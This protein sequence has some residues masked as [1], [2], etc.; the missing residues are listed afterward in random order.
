MG[1]PH[2]FA[3]M[4]IGLEVA[5]DDTTRIVEWTDSADME[6]IT[7]EISRA[8][9]FADAVLINAHVHEPTNH[10]T[11]P[12]RWLQS[13]AHACIDAGAN[14][15]LGHGPPRLRPLEI[16]ANRPIFYSMGTFMAHNQTRHLLPADLLTIRGLDPQTPASEYYATIDSAKKAAGGDAAH[17]ATTTSILPIMTFDEQGLAEIVVHVVELAPAGS[18][19]GKGTPVMASIDNAERT[20]EQLAELSAPY[21][22]GLS[23][24]AGQATWRRGDEA[25]E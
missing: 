5:D 20:L 19:A 8:K 13:L 11:Q 3:R 14:A 12:P 22:V 23:V 16:Y 24:S 1:N 6:R 18:A 25:A 2:L 17:G 15:Y 7:D 4:G 21:G 9:R 10:V